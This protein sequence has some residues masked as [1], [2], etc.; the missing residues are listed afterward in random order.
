M[1]TSEKSGLSCAKFTQCVKLEDIERDL[2]DHGG[3]N[4]GDKRP[5]RRFAW[6]ALI[7]VRSGT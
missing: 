7:K 3:L 6:P 2:L 4:K 5:A 1:A